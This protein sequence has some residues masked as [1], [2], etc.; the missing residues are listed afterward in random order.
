MTAG[1]A[2]S[3][4][5]FTE[6]PGIV[7]TAGDRLDLSARISAAAKMAAEHADAVDRGNRF[8]KEAMDMLRTQRL[9]SIMVPREYGGEGANT[10]EIADV[11]YA[12]GRGCTSTAMI[13]AM[14]QVKMACIIRHAKG[15]PWLETLLRRLPKEQ[16]LFASS[17]TEGNNGGNIRASAAAIEI[18][19]G[20]VT[21]DR[22]ASCISYGA[23]ADGIVTTA[24]RASNAD[25]SDQ[26]LLVLLKEDY[27]LEPTKTW[28]T[29]GMRGTD[30]VGYRL[31]AKARAEQVLADYH[32][33][34]A[35]SM[36]PTASIFWTA[37]WSGAA[38]AA[39]AKAQ[40]FVRHVARQ[41]GGN[42]PPGA[43]HLT[44]ALASLSKARAMLLQAAHRFDEICEDRDLVGSVGYQNEILMLKVDISELAVSIVM[45]A[46][47]AGG[48]SA[49]R[50]DTEFSMGRYLRD[51]LSSP[52]MIHNDRIRS[53]AVS[54]S[55]LSEIP[56]RLAS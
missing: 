38:A 54:T 5:I 10:T 47:R 27:T 13:Y 34:H 23:H 16:L 46:M 2:L 49:Y 51:V 18:T 42:L 36:T 8:P 45:D 43:A 3:S 31:R 20:H 41:S 22:D 11:C 21:L 37:A 24:R 26:V 40:K 28:N 30:S 6:S 53:G 55:L 56:E 1:V 15:N 29:F 48:L 33:I 14:H 50:E 19:D 39:T 9:L 4:D 25:K 17:T 7:S 35:E 44:L 32:T 52:I 12:L